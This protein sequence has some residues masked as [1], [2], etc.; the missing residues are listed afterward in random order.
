MN[1]AALPKTSH[2]RRRE[3]DDD[4]QKRSRRIELDRWLDEK[5]LEQAMKEVWDEPA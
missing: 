3:I 5:R 4:I 2:E 1:A